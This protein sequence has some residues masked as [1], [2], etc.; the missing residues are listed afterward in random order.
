MAHST[1][2]LILVS[3]VLVITPAGWVSML[4]RHLL[5]LTCMPALRLINCFVHTLVFILTGLRLEAG[6]AT[7]GRGMQERLQNDRTSLSGGTLSSS[8]LF[9]RKVAL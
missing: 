5:Q 6:R 2:V 7:G 1:G 8:H 4:M 3:S 9:H